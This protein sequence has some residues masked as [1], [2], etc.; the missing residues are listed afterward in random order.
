ML[1]SYNMNVFKKES[2]AKVNMMP[3]SKPNSQ[4][5]KVKRV[6]KWILTLLPL[7][8][9]VWASFLPLQTWMQQALILVALVWFY[10]FFLLD[11]FFLGG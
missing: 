5:N 9:V 1:E 7:G 3:S 11:T 4:P 8:G 10:V 2:Q 6:L